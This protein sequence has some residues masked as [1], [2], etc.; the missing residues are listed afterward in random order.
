MGVKK[1]E[2]DAVHTRSLQAR[3]RPGEP[4]EVRVLAPGWPGTCC[5]AALA[6]SDVSRGLPQKIT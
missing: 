1:E 4:G 3:V 5:E 2:M 6:A